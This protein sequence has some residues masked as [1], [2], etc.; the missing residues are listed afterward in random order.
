MI[1]QVMDLDSFSEPTVY[2]GIEFRSRLEAQQAIRMDL[3][4]WKWEYE[5]RRFYGQDDTYLPDFWID[6]GKRGDC[7]L[8]CKG[9][10]PD[11]I[12]AV[13]KRMEIVW[14][15]KPRA[16]LCLLIDEVE[17]LWGAHGD[18]DRL[19]RRG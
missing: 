16:F 1:R 8:E 14:D 15:T 18:G 17:G 5:P 10:F 12:R 19:W 6:M 2:R 11:D 7:Y 4:E 3:K 9:A 13:Q